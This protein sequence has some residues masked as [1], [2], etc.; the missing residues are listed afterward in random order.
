MVSAPVMTSS[1]LMTAAK[2]GCSIKNFENIACLFYNVYFYIFD[3]L[4][5]AVAYDALAGFKA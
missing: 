2:R 1:K 5:N 4:V 3:D